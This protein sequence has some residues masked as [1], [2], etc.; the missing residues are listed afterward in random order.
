MDAVTRIAVAR[1]LVSR[2]LPYYSKI[3]LG[4]RPKLVEGLGTV[5]VTDDMVLLIDPAVV[6]GKWPERVIPGAFTHEVLHV[7]LRHAK[8]GKPLADSL[9][10]A[11][12]AHTWN[13]ACDFEC[14]RIVRG[15][16]LEL[17][18]G[19]VFA[20]KYSLDPNI[21]AEE[22]YHK[23][24]KQNQQQQQQQGRQ[25]QQQQGGAGQQGQQGQQG[26]PDKGTF[27]AGKCGGCAG[28]PVAGERD[29]VGEGEGAGH[30]EREAVEQA[31]AEAIIDAEA[32]RPGSV[33]AEVLRDAQARVAASQTPWQQILSRHMRRATQRKRGNRDYTFAR[34]HRRQGTLAGAHGPIMPSTFEPVIEVAVVVDTSGS[35]GEAEIALALTEIDGLIRAS[36]ASALVL[37]CDAQVHA[38]G[39]VARAADAARLLKG[40]GGTDFRPAFKAL[41]RDRPALTV[42]VTDGY[43]PAPSHAPTWTDTV[44]CLVGKYTT[45]PC[46][47]GEVV[48]VK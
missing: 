10:V 40:G 48:E 2:K 30:L 21:L 36:G 13:L 47:W 39:K 3:T 4:L 42:V 17:P 45:K 14:N 22:A 7:A 20:E 26:Q 18:E 9:G 23:L 6:G 15:I 28:N 44:W 1:A 25:N 5:A 43:G 35:M 11:F 33:P 24:V 19:A 29:H 41:E 32:K 34:P 46:N 27:A 12:D 31:V 38:R 8:R 16:G 37:S